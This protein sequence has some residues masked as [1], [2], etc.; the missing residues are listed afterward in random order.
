[1][2][3]PFA[4]EYRLACAPDVD[5]PLGGVSALCELSMLQDGPWPTF[6]TTKAQEHALGLAAGARD[7]DADESEEPTCV[8]LLLRRELAPAPECAIDPV[9]A[10]LSLPDDVRDDPRVAGEIEYVL[11]RVLRGDSVEGN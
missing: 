11:N 6:A 8:V 7:A 9:T 1:M 10:I 5:L 4:R 2:A 3:S